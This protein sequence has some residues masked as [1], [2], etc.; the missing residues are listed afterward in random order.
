MGE[1][2][3]Q[4]IT[5][6][7]PHMSRKD[8]HTLKIYA[9]SVRTSKLDQDLSNLQSVAT[10]IHILK[11]CTYLVQKEIWKLRRLNFKAAIGGI[12]AAE[13]KRLSDEFEATK[14]H[15]EEFVRNFNV[16]GVPVLCGH[17]QQTLFL[18]SQDKF[19][20]SITLVSTN[21]LPN[22][23]YSLTYTAEN[24]AASP[25]FIISL[26]SETGKVSEITYEGHS[27]DPTTP[28]HLSDLEVVFNPLTPLNLLKA[29]IGTIND[30]KLLSVDVKSMIYP[31]KYKIL[32][33]KSSSGLEAYLGRFSATIKNGKAEVGGLAL[34]FSRHLH[35]AE[36]NSRISEVSVGYVTRNVT[37]QIETGI[38]PLTLEFEVAG[39]RQALELMPML[40]ESLHGNAFG[41]I[42]TLADLSLGTGFDPSVNLEVLEA[43]NL[44][45]NQYD[46]ILSDRLTYLKKLFS[47]QYASERKLPHKDP[48]VL[49]KAIED[50][51]KF[52][53]FSVFLKE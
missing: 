29:D 25:V 41:K 39:K 51:L 34:E 15:L 26:Y 16:N 42:V 2:E 33:Q 6:N 46:K 44:R 18:L 23:M 47:S 24:V 50:K 27:L 31:G 43:I 28:L 32:V 48:T 35:V 8:P 13:R 53:P 49:L 10:L 5:L 38:L 9:E 12:D 4:V 52:I 40:P 37:V 30:A 36:P 17:R 7:Y 21:A 22:G 11:K 20:K 19:I 45:L 14:Q 1:R 3:L